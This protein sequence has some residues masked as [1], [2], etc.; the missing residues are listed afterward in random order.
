M[1]KAI[2]YTSNAGSTAEYAKLLGEKILLPCY[3]LNVATEKL[4]SGDEI[5][6]LGWIMASEI[7]GYK[8]ASKKYKVRVACAVGM[9]GTGTQIKE[10]RNKSKIPDSIPVFTLQGQFDLKKLTGMYKM[11]MGMMVKTAGKALSEKTDRTPDEDVMLEM[12]QHG[13][14]HVCIE[15]LSSVI[16]WYDSSVTM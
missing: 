10:V 16:K 14:N 2:I 6:Y 15:N 1:I 9:G 3:D 8:E 4:K 11:M 5:I 13:G 7:K 12:M